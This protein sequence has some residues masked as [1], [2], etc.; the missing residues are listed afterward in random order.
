MLNRVLAIVASIVLLMIALSGC[1]GQEVPEEA[2]V[3]TPP[4]TPGSTVSGAT[5]PP[6]SPTV[7]SRTGPTNPAIP[8]TRRR[9]VNQPPATIP[10]QASTETP[11]HTTAAPTEVTESASSEPANYLEE[12]IPPCTPVVGS[13]EDPCEPGVRAASGTSGTIS[14]SPASGETPSTVREYLDGNSLIFVSHIVLRGT[15]IPDSVRCT[16]DNPFHMPSYEEPGYFQNSL[17]MQCYAD[18]RVNAYVLGSGPAQLTVLNQSLDEM[19]IRGRKDWLGSA[20]EAI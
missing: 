3:I 14:S 19:Y 20:S 9:Q 4:P 10:E 6:P 1:R 2:D 17:L 11:L 16:R 18:V 15:Y 13:A 5:A 7:A 8:P 12:D